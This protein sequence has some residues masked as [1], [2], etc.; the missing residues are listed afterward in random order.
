MQP[1]LFLLLVKMLPLSFIYVYL[2]GNC[3]TILG[4]FL[5]YINM[6]QPYKDAF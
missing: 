4:W 6:I 5:P 2:E 1:I 3:F